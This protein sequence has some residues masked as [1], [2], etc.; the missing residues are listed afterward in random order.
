MI[1]FAYMWI[2]GLLLT[3]LFIVVAIIVEKNFDE[4]Q[5]IMKWWRRNVIG[6][7]PQDKTPHN[8]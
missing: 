5:P 2:I 6:P 4:S 1:I 3:T 7:D 8:D